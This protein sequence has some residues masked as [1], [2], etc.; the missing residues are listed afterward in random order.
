MDAQHYSSRYKDAACRRPPVSPSTRRS[1]RAT[2]LWIAEGAV[3][4]PDLHRCRAGCQWAG[5]ATPPADR[6]NRRITC[7]EMEPYDRLVMEE[8]LHAIF[9]CCR[10]RGRRAFVSAASTRGHNPMCGASARDGSPAS[11]PT[12]SASRAHGSSQVR[13]LARGWGCVDLRCGAAIRTL[14]SPMQARSGGCR[15]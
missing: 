8:R 12:G 15:R 7:N 4:T 1:A 10:A 14:L 9:A 6:S 2:D 11:P 13:G 3:P 5:A